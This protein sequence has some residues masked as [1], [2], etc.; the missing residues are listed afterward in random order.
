MNASYGERGFIFLNLRFYQAFLGVIF[1][2][3]NV[4]LLQSVAQCLINNLLRRLY[5]F[6]RL[7][8]F[9]NGLL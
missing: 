2:K 8:K 9:L 5:D 3:D 1:H 4:L 6:L 7:L